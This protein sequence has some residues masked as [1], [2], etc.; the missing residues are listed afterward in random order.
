MIQNSPIVQDWINQGMEKGMAIGGSSVMQ[1]MI[2][3]IL[4]DRLGIVKQNVIDEI[5]ALKSLDM[6]KALFRKSLHVKDIDEF[7]ELLKLTSC[8]MKC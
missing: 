3:E 5:K 7:R 1:E 8:S 2:I 4:Q 6:L